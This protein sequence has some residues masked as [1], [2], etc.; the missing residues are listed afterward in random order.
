MSQSIILGIKRFVAASSILLILF[1]ISAQA[2]YEAGV[3]YFELP[4][5]LAVSGDGIEVTEYFSYGCNHCYQFEPILAA[6]VKTLPDDVTFTRTPAMWNKGYSF[7]AQTYYTL[8]AMDVLDKMHLE[9]FNAIH[10]KRQNIGDPEA[11]ADF[12]AELEPSCRDTKIKL[13]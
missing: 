5:P 7:L 2:E 13:P 8:L 1:S 11:M 9:I 4:T 10:L 12:L 6:W 3:H